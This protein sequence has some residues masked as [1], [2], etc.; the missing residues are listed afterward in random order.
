MGKVN[1]FRL[2]A[3]VLSADFRCLEDQVKQLEEAGVDEIHVDVM[4]GHFVPNLTMG[5]FIVSTLKR[6]THLPLDVHLMVENPDRMIPWYAEAGAHRLSVQVE[7]CPHIHRT[8]QNIHSLGCEAGVV[9]NP[10]T[11]ASWLEEVVLYADLILVMTVNPGFSGQS[12]L[13]EVLP[14]IAKVRD[15]V[16]NTHSKA[17]IQVDGGIDQ[18]TLPLV[19]AAG[20][21]Y[22]VS[23]TAIFKHPEGIKA[24]VNALRESVQKNIA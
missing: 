18:N 19:Y 22:I 16:E 14:K 11:P 10:G 21:R 1:S 23:A 24:G 12:F 8:L 17:V 9:L 20:A 5:P 7:T 6:I 2:C 15:L 4:D 3:S 13:P